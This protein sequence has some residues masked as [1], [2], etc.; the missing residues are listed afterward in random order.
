MSHRLLE[1]NVRESEQMLVEVDGLLATLEDAWMAI[2]P[3]AARMAA[4]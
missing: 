3:D 4:A 2:A 1:A